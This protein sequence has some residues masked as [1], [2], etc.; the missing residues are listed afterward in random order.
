MGVVA[1]QR[2]CCPVRDGQ[3]GRASAGQADIEV[4]RARQVQ[5]QVAPPVGRIRSNKA[6]G[7]ATVQ[8]RMP[9]GDAGIGLAPADPRQAQAKFHHGRGIG[10][11]P[12]PQQVSRSESKRST[13]T[14]T[15]A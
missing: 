13:R 4:S 15:P 10:G 9:G 14:S 11:W 1:G 3:Q 12:D 6:R 5:H 2:T 8:A 7:K